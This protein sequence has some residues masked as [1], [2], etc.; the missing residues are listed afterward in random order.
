MNRPN[1]SQLSQALTQIQEQQFLRH[2]FRQ[3]GK[4]KR[5]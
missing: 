5:R 3:T 2:G 1:K 4:R